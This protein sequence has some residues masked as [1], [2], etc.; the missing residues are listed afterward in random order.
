[1][2]LHIILLHGCLQDTLLHINICEQRKFNDGMQ[3]I[4]LIENGKKKK[5]KNCKTQTISSV[6]SCEKY[7][8]GV[9]HL[10]HTISRHWNGG[11]EDQGFQRKLKKFYNTRQAISDQSVQYI[12]LEDTNCPNTEHNTTLKIIQKL[13]CRQQWKNQKQQK[14]FWRRMNCVVE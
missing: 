10:K 13:W 2:G 4:C 9:S 12:K 11:Q 14:I 5:E 6:K 8:M 3:N 7:N 1:M